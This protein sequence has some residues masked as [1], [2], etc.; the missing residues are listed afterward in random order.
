MVCE[1]LDAASNCGFTP[2]RSRF[3]GLLSDINECIESQFERISIVC[4]FTT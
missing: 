4:Y 1:K 3:C 2:D